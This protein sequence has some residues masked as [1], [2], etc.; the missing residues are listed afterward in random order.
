M[1]MDEAIKTINNYCNGQGKSCKG[2]PLHVYAS[3]NCYLME[4]VPCDW[5]LPKDLFENIDDYI[6]HVSSDPEIMGYGK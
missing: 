3:A 6:Q 1:M 5:N 2:C 4:V